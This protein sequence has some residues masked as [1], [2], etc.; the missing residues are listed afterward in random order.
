M[1][2]IQAGDPAARLATLQSLKDLLPDLASNILNLYARAWTFTE[3]KIPPLSFSHSAIRLAKLLTAVRKEHGHLND[4]VLKSIVLSRPFHSQNLAPD[5]F[6]PFVSTSELSSLLL[7]AHPTQSSKDSMPISDRTNILAAI[8]SVLSELGYHRKKAVVLKELLSALL[9]ALVQARKDG[10]AEMG[11]HPAASLASLN[12]ATGNGLSEQLGAKEDDVEQSMRHFLSLVCQSFGI[13]PRVQVHDTSQG[14]G[15]ELAESSARNT[16]VSIALAIQ[17]ASTN[18]IGSQDLKIDILR[19]CINICEALPNLA[20]AL[21]YSAELLRTAGS[22]IAPGPESS[23]GSPSLP[24]EEQMRLANNISR[25]LSAAQHLGVQHP[26]AEYWDEFLVRRVEIV[27]GNSS[28]ALVPHAKSELEIA[29]TIEAKKEKNPFIYNPFLKATAS[30]VVELLLVASEEAVFRVTLQNLYDFDLYIERIQLE[31]D[32]RQF[33]SHPQ[34]IMIGPYRTQTMLLNGIPQTP[35]ILNV[36]GCLVKIRGCRERS[37]SIFRE[38]W[39]L[40]VDVKGR[41]IQPDAVNM[42]RKQ[43]DSPNLSAEKTKS[44]MSSDR[45]KASPLTLSIIDAQ[46]SLQ[47]AKMSLPQSAIMLLEGETQTFTITLQNNSHTTSAD[48]VLLSFNDSTALQVQSALAS[49]ELSEIE[50]YELE[51][52]TSRKQSFRWLRKDGQQGV[53]E[54]GIKIFP[55]GETILQIEVLGKPGLSYGT[56]QVDYSYLGI[57]TIDIKDRFYT[58]Q[59]KIPLAVTVNSGVDLVRSDLTPLPSDFGYQGQQELVSE[60]NGHRHD[61][62]TS[63]QPEISTLLSNFSISPIQSHPY[64]LLLLDFRNSWPSTLTLSLT[65]FDASTTSTDPKDAIT[66][67]HPIP[68]GITLRIPL[69]H[70]KLYLPLSA[71]YAPIPT[72]NPAT[73]RQFVVSTSAKHSPEA[74]LALREAFWYREELLKRLSAR[75]VEEGTGRNGEVEMRALRLTGRMVAGLRKEDVEVGMVVAAAEDAVDGQAGGDGKGEVVKQVGKQTFQVST[76]TFLNLKTTLHNRSEAPIRPLLRLQPTLAGQPH[77]IALDLGKKLLVNGVLQQ[78]LPVLKP[79]GKKMVENGFCAL[80]AGVYEWSACVEE[81]RTDE[82]GKGA[83]KD[84]MYEGGNGR[85]RAKTGEFY[86]LGAIG[87]RVWY[88]EGPCVVV[89][90]DCENVGALGIPAEIGGGLEPDC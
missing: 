88:G 5:D 76:G 63:T 3:D 67:H 27:E 62:R 16:A 77:N 6:K 11:V 52:S 80:S 70:P 20:G 39:E 54:D 64:T 59:L 90:Q 33:K 53:G 26:E 45:P 37:F 82:K 4:N 71:T 66:T 31:A 44:K 56:I 55:R 47:L 89:A 28:K 36:T 61:S 10:A 57:P 43:H 60:Q 12:A 24:I 14:N 22:G 32:D 65:L 48:L 78:A 1:G 42:G 86:V 58:R 79:G 21:Q 68:P 15:I 35:G 9:P 29:E 40:K 83:G 81:V 46:P 19:S 50:L 8:A 87:R 69:P 75:W 17:Q 13:L 49:K 38:P 18:Q 34:S 51:L 23:N 85:Q 25:T 41:N 30:A 73:A 84:G 7:R 72:L 2:P 74:E